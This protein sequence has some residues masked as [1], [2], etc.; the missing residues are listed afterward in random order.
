MIIFG[1]S[2]IRLLVN[3]VSGQEEGW[4]KTDH[5]FKLLG[6]TLS[7]FLI[8]EG[9]VAIVYMAPVIADIGGF[10]DAIII[11]FGIQLIITGAFVFF[12]WLLRGHPIR[13]LDISNHKLSRLLLLLVGVLIVI[14]AIGLSYYVSSFYSSTHVRGFWIAGAAGQLFVIG[15][16]VIFG[17]TSLYPE[18]RTGGWARSVAYFCSSVIAG[19]G[20]FV[21]GTS[22]DIYLDPHSMIAGETVSII[23]IQLFLLGALP[24]L[25]LGFRNKMVLG[26]KMFSHWLFSHIPLL[27]MEIAAIEGLILL[28]FSQPV[29]IEGIGGIRG[30]WIAA[31]GVQLFFLGISTSISWLWREAGFWETKPTTI[32]GVFTG[33]TLISEGLFTIGVSAPIRVA[34]VGGMLERTVDIA[35]VQLVLL[36]TVLTIYWIMKD[37]KIF[38]RSISDSRPFSFISLLAGLIVT[39]EG[40]IV[41]AYTSNV[42]LDGVGTIRFPWMALAGSQL[43]ILGGLSVL[44][45]YWRDVERCRAGITQIAG[46]IISMIIMAEGLFIMAIAEPMRIDGIGGVLDRTVAAA[47]AQ[48]IFLGA[49]MLGSRILEGKGFFVRKIMGFRI[50]EAI[51]YLAAALVAVEGLILIIFA[52]DIYITGFGGI[53]SKYI[54]IAGLQLFALAIAY[55]VFWVWRYEELG[56][57]QRQLATSGIMFL[58][59]LLPLALVL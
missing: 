42:T 6:I 59:L 34:S 47:G 26:R 22:A 43:F 16:M 30:F 25:I 23:G 12:F 45:W 56:L 4:W 35:G 19:E 49:V 37:H 10:L 27:F 39:L 41:L 9:A 13:G 15:A 32:I 46:P 3:R 36:G 8:A 48:L 20:L 18:T 54:V 31:G 44:S 52:A 21:I 38:G 11:P 33:V 29:E 51:A 2:I 28:A 17:W 58:S 14:E 7:I 53:S 55:L 50:S 57:K 40:L 1:D 5:W 24:A